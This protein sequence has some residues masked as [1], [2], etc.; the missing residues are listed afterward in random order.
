MIMVVDQCEVSSEGCAVR[1]QALGG[2]GVT[3]LSVPGGGGWEGDLL[4][5]PVDDP[6]FQTPSF[7]VTCS[8]PF[9]VN[10]SPG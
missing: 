4:C 5:H 8:L 10:N 2:K 6:G 1:V 3:V 7:Q 9:G